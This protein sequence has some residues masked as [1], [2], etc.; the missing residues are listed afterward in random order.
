MKK[1][2][3]PVATVGLVFA[4]SGCFQNPLEAAVE[5]A[6]EE[7]VERAL[8][9]SGAEVDLDFS[10]DISLPEGWP[11][12]VP[13][14]D[15]NIISTYS[16]DGTMTVMVE[17]A[18]PDVAAAA[19][20]DIENAGFTVGSESQVEGF[21]SAGLESADY[22]VIFTSTFDGDVTMVSIVVAPLNM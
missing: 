1:Y 10:G 11:S 12:E 19:L 21:Y 20:D 8:E 3:A 17:V 16:V 6:A 14:P 15:G 13:V 18:S 4:L 22:S 5:R 9:E 2:L 7:T